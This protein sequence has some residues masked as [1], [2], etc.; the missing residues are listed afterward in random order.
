MRQLGRNCLSFILVALLTGVALELSFQG[1]YHAGIGSPLPCG[2]RTESPNMGRA[3]SVALKPGFVGTSRRG[4]TYA[5]NELGFRDDA[6]DPG[7]RHIVF[8]GDSTTFGL[9]ICHEATFPE[10]IERMLASRGLAVQCVNTATPGQATLDQRDIL[11]RLLELEELRPAAVVLAFF[12]NDFPGNMGYAGH[13]SK[14]SQSLRRWAAPV[15]GLRTW[16]VLRET[17]TAIRDRRAQPD[18]DPEAGVL[19]LDEMGEYAPNRGLEVERDLLTPDQLRNN[20][21]Y[22]MTVEAIDEVAETVA[23]LGLPFVFV[24]MPTGDAEIRTGKCPRYKAL[25]EAHVA[26]REGIIWVDACKEYRLHL[27]A[28]DDVDLPDGFYSRRGDAAHPGPT[29]CS[30]LAAVLSDILERKLEARPPLQQRA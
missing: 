6:I 12:C 18:A 1:L 19:P 14:Q 25:L 20:R 15:R 10:V 23:S 7:K 5:V 30:V 24:Y 8:L 2:I 3:E 21:S 17:W 13:R 4:I 28:E 29:A 16:R 11:G 9:N 22:I 27:S 26:G